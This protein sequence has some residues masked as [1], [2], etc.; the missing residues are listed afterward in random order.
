MDQ[1]LVLWLW[2]G[3][4]PTMMGPELARFTPDD[5]VTR[6]NFFVFTSY[7]QISNCR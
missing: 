1:R 7:S 3:I 6:V 5:V 4:G 2:L